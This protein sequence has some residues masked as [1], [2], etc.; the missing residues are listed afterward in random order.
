M[1]K[2]CTDCGH[3][4][5]CGL[6]PCFTYDATVGTERSCGTCINRYSCAALCPHYHAA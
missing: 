3:K 6:K 1:V 4:L 5:H 2:S